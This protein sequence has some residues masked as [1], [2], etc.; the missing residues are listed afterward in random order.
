[1]TI[2]SFFF[3]RETYPPVLLESK[4]AKLCKETGN[5]NIQSALNSGLTAKE[6]FF[7]AITRPL[8]FLFLS[9]IVF[10]LSLYSAVS[11]GVLYL[12]FTTFPG[13]FQLIYG[14][15]TGTV[16]LSY[17][18]LGLGFSLGLFIFGGLSDV[19]VKR[20]SVGGPPKPEYRMPLLVIG[21][22]FFPIGLFWYGWAAEFHVHWTVP[23]IGTTWVGVA[24][25]LSF[26]SYAP[27]L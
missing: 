7:S 1:M 15:S 16:G 26:V 9:P 17:L 23:I 18:G 11:Y 25:I 19:L 27:Y 12:L 20:L 4:A 22:I 14:F 8:K 6:L 10:I 3:M 21:A 2:L 24:L 5:P 13:T